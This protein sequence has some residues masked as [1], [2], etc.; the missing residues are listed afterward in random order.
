MTLPVPP[1][2]ASE[3]E[4]QQLISLL[5]ATLESTGDG[6]L[7][8]DDEGRIAASN[9]Q[10]EMMWRIPPE[11]LAARDDERCIAFVLD[12]LISPEQFLSKVRELYATPDAESFDELDFKDGRIFE[13]YSQPRRIDGRAAG[14]VWSF[15]DVTE[16]RR[17]EEALAKERAF[18]REVIDI[19]P[20]FIFAK[21]RAGRFTLVNQ[22][23]AEAYGTTVERLIGKTDADFNPDAAEVA[24]FRRDDLDVIEGKRTEL[25]GRLQQRH[26]HLLPGGAIHSAPRRQTGSHRGEVDWD[27]TPSLATALADVSR[28]IVFGRCVCLDRV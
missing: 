20:N 2:R 13:R 4:L 1:A 26:A 15:R 23:V 17:A 18:L 5:R 27:E 21:D 8:V 9:R 6:I 3:A 28:A 11:V 16:R 14:R 10:F 19:N 12:Q 7:V 24:R 25:A 22:A